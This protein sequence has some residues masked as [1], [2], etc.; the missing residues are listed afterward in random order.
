MISADME[1]LYGDMEVVA[2]LLLCTQITA[3]GVTAQMLA[4]VHGLRADRMESIGLFY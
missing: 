1:Q 3:A 4:Y 2:I